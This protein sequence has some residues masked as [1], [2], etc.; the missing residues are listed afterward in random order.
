MYKLYY[1]INLDENNNNKL[2]NLNTV[3]FTSQFSLAYLPERDDNMIRYDDK[4]IMFVY[5]CMYFIP[6]VGWIANL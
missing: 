5:I 3:F 1:Y 6:V 4:T 2:I